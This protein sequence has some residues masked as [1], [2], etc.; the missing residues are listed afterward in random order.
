[1]TSD[2]S[3]L[4]AQI[5]D[6]LFKGASEHLGPIGLAAFFYSIGLSAYLQGEHFFGFAWPRLGAFIGLAI[7]NFL[8]VLLVLYLVVE[9]GLARVMPKLV[10]RIS[11]KEKRDNREGAIAFVA[12]FII[13][14]LFAAGYLWTWKTLF[15]SSATNVQQIIE[16]ERR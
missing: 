16:P 12:C 7:L 14:V 8:I 5:I 15:S 9:K 6:S 4:I 3:G 1:M 2:H 13:I 10:S 11:D